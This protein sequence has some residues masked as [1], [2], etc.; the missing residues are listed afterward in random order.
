MSAF[1]CKESEALS[2]CY[3]SSITRVGHNRPTL[4]AIDNAIQKTVVG[5]GLSGHMLGLCVPRRPK[6]TN[7]RRALRALSKKKPV[8]TH[9]GAMGGPGMD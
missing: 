1:A 2:G 9:S 3:F 6:G 8:L 7:Y 5:E 4:I